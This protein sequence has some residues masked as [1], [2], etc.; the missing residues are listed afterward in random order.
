M[1]RKSVMAILVG[2]FV[3]VPWPVF[4]ITCDECLNIEKEKKKMRKELSDSGEDL[5]EA[6]QRQE[7]VKVRGLRNRINELRKKLIDLR[8]TDVECRDACRPEE[9]KKSECQRLR[10][11]IVELETKEAQSEDQIK[12]VD[13]LYAK[14]LKCNEEWR[15]MIGD[16]E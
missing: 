10:R 16:Y 4:S 12:K 1:F 13:E 3:M 2:L 15:R 5:K 9:V 7:Y 6:F 14:L 11:E 8:K